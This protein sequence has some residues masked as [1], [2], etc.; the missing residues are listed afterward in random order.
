M[1]DTSGNSSKKKFDFNLLTRIFRYA[2]PY[3]VKFIFSLVLALVLALLSPLRPLLINQTLTEVNNASALKSIDVLNFL[4]WITFFQIALLLVETVIRFYFT[5]LSSWLGHRVV[6]D[7]RVHVFEKV[8]SLNLRQFDKTPIGTLTTRTINDL[9]SINDVFAEGLIPIIADFLSIV[10]I[11]TAMLY[12]DW[13][14]TLVCLLPFPILILATYFFKESV[15]K[16]FV[17]VRNAVASLNA[18][19]QEHISGMMVIQSFTAEK[20][21]EQKFNLINQ[22]HRNANIHAIFAYSVFF[23]VVEVVL[24]LS[25]GILV[26]YAATD[27][28]QMDP[29][30]ALQTSGKI[31]SFILL[32]NM[33][34]R[35]LRVIADK[36]NVLQMG[37]VAGERVMVLL[38]NPDTLEDSASAKDYPIQGEIEFDRVSF[39]Y[40][41]HVPVLSEISFQASKGQTLAIVG[42]TGSGKSSIISLIS[43]LYQHQSGTI[44]IDGKSIDEF[45][46]SSL[47]RGIAV[48]LQD[49]YLFSGSILDNLTLRNSEIEMERV[50]KAAQLIGIHDFIMKLPGGYS[51]EVMERGATLSMGQRQ[52]LSF[53]RALLY[54]PAI[55][56]LDEAT[57]SVDSESEQLIQNAIEILTSGRTSIV[58][59][60]RLSTIQ[61]ADQI[62]LLEKGR[63]VEK[64][65]HKELVNRGG[66]YAR[67]IELQSHSKN[68]E[69]F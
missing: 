45:S 32:L 27:A 48:V 20:K 12:T 58:I 15:N 40:D 51:Y 69:V 13:Q 59:A 19:V 55:L 8:L 5:Y 37:M 29:A 52:L 66:A 56:I 23:P 67:L 53:I 42:P 61:K 14:L 64:G 60:H 68:P 17:N 34:F 54:D 57:S 39:S 16:S 46:I 33:L 21:E 65:T 25:L 18:F 63:I 43:R 44:R 31:V 36:F 30:E 4:F 49:V 3:R 50:V 7:M 38:D 10:A 62:L 11:L 28:F 41:A 47:R 9:E 22:R 35:P 2:K 6:K 24:A 26:W 1:S